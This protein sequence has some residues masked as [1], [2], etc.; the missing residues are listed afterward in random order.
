MKKM[1][2]KKLMKKAKKKVKDALKADE[3]RAEA[4]LDGK[5]VG[6]KKKKDKSKDE[7]VS[8]LSLGLWVLLFIVTDGSTTMSYLKNRFLENLFGCMKKLFSIIY[9]V[10]LNDLRHLRREEQEA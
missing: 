10:F 2:K 9:T 7:E 4:I 8:V 3:K 1:K 5:L 6:K